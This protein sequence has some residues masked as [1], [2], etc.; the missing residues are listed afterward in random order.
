MGAAVSRFL[1][2][3][4]ADVNARETKN[5]MTPLL[6]ATV[7]NHRDTVRLLLD[8]GADPRVVDKDG[9]TLLM[10]AVLKNNPT[11]VKLFLE[12]GVEVNAKAKDGSTA[13][14]W[15]RRGHLEDI[16]EMLV[17]AGAI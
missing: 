9:K 12:K 15:A 10:W 4:G 5:R 8:K 14:Y 6:A 1:L 2:D 16:E 11:L 17:K 7:G 13:L 3:K